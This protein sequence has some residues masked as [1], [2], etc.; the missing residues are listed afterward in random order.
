MNLPSDLRGEIR[1]GQRYFPAG[2][3]NGNPETVLAVA[4]CD[5]APFEFRSFSGWDAEGGGGGQTLADATGN[6]QPAS[7][8]QEAAAQALSYEEAVAAA[9][10]EGEQEGRRLARLELDAEMRERIERERARLME[11]VQQFTA[12]RSRYFAE[13][14]QQVVKLSLAIAARVLHRETVVDPMLLTGVVR[15]A[16]EKMADRSGVVLRVPEHDG[17]AWEQVFEGGALTGRPRVIEDA[18]LGRGECVLE[19]TMGTVELGVKAQLEEIEKGFLDL[20]N[21]RPNA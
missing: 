7:W 11:T 12:T 19:S 16:L 13:V 17:R 6:P 21:Q 10:M 14:E 18:G 9:R 5:V 3:R 1:S 8:G 4:A 20:L 2:T 15:V